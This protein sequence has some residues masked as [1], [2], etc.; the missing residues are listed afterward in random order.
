MNDRTVFFDDLFVYAPSMAPLLEG[1]SLGTAK[2][3]DIMLKK[4]MLIPKDLEP[5]FLAVERKKGQTVGA[6]ILERV[7]VRTKRKL[8]AVV[9]G[10]T[11]GKFDES[12]LRKSAVKTMKT[13]WR[14]VFLAGLRAG[15]TVGEG[16]GPGKTTVKLD[17][18]DD[19]WV[20]GAMT[21][22][23]RF[24]NGFIAAL[25]DSTYK[26]DPLKRADMYVDALAS[27]YESARVIA[28]PGNV[29]VFWKGPHD[30]KTCESC[31]YLFEHSPFT[32][33]T[34]PTT[35]RSGATLCLTN[36][37]DRL[38]IRRVPHEVEEVDAHGALVQR[39]KHVRDL[40][41]IKHQGHL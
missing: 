23:M 20:K 28:L 5:E 27:F 39:D 9:R 15:G 17:A 13:A 3:K 26:M 14:E 4:D 19:L 10:Y 21:H 33:W 38:F 31:R 11:E 6:R 22:E 18:G 8:R 29:H 12:E 7:Q 37:R 25:V 16:A 41:K 34:L 36:C 30:H 35:P 40:R 1:K 2:L 32:K 24:L